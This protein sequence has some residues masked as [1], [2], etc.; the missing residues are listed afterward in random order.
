ME[1]K[2]KH[3]TLIHKQTLKDRELRKL[4]KMELQLNVINESLEQDKSQHRRLK[5]EVCMNIFIIRI[6]NFLTGNPSM[7]SFDW[8]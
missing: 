2:Q 5:T 6:P 7:K 8:S 1:K 3:D 4:K